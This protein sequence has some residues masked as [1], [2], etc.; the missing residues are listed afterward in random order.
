MSNILEGSEAYLYTYGHLFDP[1]LDNR[2]QYVDANDG[3]NLE[4]LPEKKGM[5]R[6]GNGCPRSP[7]TVTTSVLLQWA[8]ITFL[9][10]SYARLEGVMLKI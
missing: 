10:I 2:V 3:I 6:Y 4:T 5:I 1:E 7:S 8:L 9:L